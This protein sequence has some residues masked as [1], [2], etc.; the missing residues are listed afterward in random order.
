MLKK[1][2]IIGLC[3]SILWVNYPGMMNPVFA[4]VAP[5][6][7]TGGE[8]SIVA[9]GYTSGATLKL[10]LTNG[11]LKATEPTVTAATYSFI[12]VEP[13]PLGYYVTQTVGGVESM[14]SAFVS[15]SLRTPTA[16]AGIGY[17]DA[18]NIYPGASIALYESSGQAI[19]AVPV[20]QGNGKFRFS[21]LTAR[22]TYYVTQSINGVVSGG[23]T[24]ATVQP[25]VPNAPAAMGEEESIRVSGYTSGATLKLYLTNGTLKATEPTVTAATYSFIDVEPNSLGYYVTQ[26]VGGEESTNSAFVSAGL[27]TPT[28]SAGIGYID[29]GSIYPGASIT[30]YE[31]GG[32]A[33]PAIPVEQDNGKF[34]FSGLTARTTYYVIQSI[35]G[36]TSANSNFATVQPSVPDAPAAAGEEESINVSGY[37]SGA[38][39]KLYLANGTLKATEPTVTAATYSFKD[40]EPNSLGYYV[41]QTVDGE[42]SVNSAFVSASLRTPTASAGIGYLDTGNIYPGASITL[43][44]SGGQALP[45]VP[46][47]QD[48]GKFRFSGL[49]ARTAYYVTQS[50][51]GVISGGSTLATVLPSV[52]DAP[53]ATGEEESIRVSGYT[54]GA[55]LKLYLTNGTLKATASSVTAA[56]YKFLNVEP[57]TMGYY[58]TQ[59]L[60]GEES[61]NSSFVNAKLRTP[62]AAAGIAYVDVSNVYPGADVTLFEYTGIEVSDTPSDLG[63]GAFRF[64]GLT[65]TQSYYAV[66]S[67]NGVISEATRIVTVLP[68]PSAQLTAGAGNRQVTL[69]WSSVTGATYYNI[70]MQAPGEKLQLLETTDAVT[71]SYEAL[72]LAN[73]KTYMFVVRAGN[74]GGLGTKSNEVTVTPATVPSAPTGISAV[75]GDGSATITFIPPADDGGFA[76]TEYRVTASPGN[77]VAKG[78]GSPVTVTGLVNGT[79]YTFTVEAVNALGSSEASAKSNTVVPAAPYSGGGTSPAQPTA[80]PASTTADVLVNGKVE[81]AGTIVT[82]SRGDQT[83]AT[84]IVDT[85]KLQQRLAEEGKQAVIT[86]PYSGQ[87]AVV[88]AELTGQMIKFMEDQQVTLL[89]QTGAGS[90][91]LPTSQIQIA[92]LAQK[93]DSSA[94]DIKVQIEISRLP[95][96]KLQVVNQ[97]AA[98]GSFTLV[99]PPA[100]FAVRAIHGSATAEVSIFNTYVERMLVLP[101]GIDPDQIT[102]GITVDPDGKVRHIPTRLVIAGGKV[103]AKMNSL[104]NSIYAV[105]WHPLEFKDLTGHWARQ[106]VNDMGSRMVIEGTGG[107]LF[108]PDRDI[109]RAEFVAI[110]VRGLGIKPMTGQSAFADVNPTDWYHGFIQAAQ[111]Y[112]LVDG[113]ADGKFL[114]NE[115]ITREQATVIIGRAMSLTNL[116]TRLAVQQTSENLR[117]YADGAEVSPWAASGMI[118][119]IQSGIINGR[120]STILAPAAYITRAEVATIIQRL[121]QKS[122]LI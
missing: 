96:S 72:G 20:D 64:N 11:T 93:L 7:A 81:S 102:T 73:G 46:V 88:I 63:N 92:S 9:S 5:P 54:S 53:A 89:L 106:A 86:I 61:V 24:L 98:Q 52:P 4:A 83:V 41:T 45:A 22:T 112:K 84:I 114:P 110:L 30:L 62:V 117:S 16:S 109:T 26:T 100:D 67:I 23:S 115:R 103:Y 21:G 70:Y 76:V 79:S 71:T 28:A 107:N 38:T 116:K 113:F 3:L 58:V 39:L 14:N 12:N 104:T 121:L 44:E 42:E 51:N 55:N 37:T 69:N 15:A 94:E 111:A 36:V 27:R 13:N 18:G 19:S 40:V 33:L 77:I 29:A 25:S 97:A 57:H 34:R 59:T 2:L 101:D 50:I 80:A 87:A 95:E 91:T 105:V 108:S 65:A 35:N 68:L 10:Y 56:T 17:I 60:D 31:S 6:S 48:N 82:S 122:D 49:T 74:A 78:T 47:E 66:Q 85:G 99:G 1:I 90:F 118:S 119:S 75:A 8:E 32:Q 43:Y 120:S